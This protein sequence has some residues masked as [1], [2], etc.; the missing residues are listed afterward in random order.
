MKS[1]DVE[2]CAVYTGGVQLYSEASESTW[3]RPK[4]CHVNT[5]NKCVLNFIV[6]TNKINLKPSMQPW[7]VERRTCTQPKAHLSSSVCGLIIYALCVKVFMQAQLWCDLNAEVSFNI[8]EVKPRGNDYLSFAL[9]IHSKTLQ[10]RIINMQEYEK[11]ENFYIVLEEPK[12]L[13][14]GISGLYVCTY[15]C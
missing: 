7:F 5:L 10:V 13:K 8:S 2:I 9:C 12:W 14:R 15:P 3:Q 1:D 11:R 4:S 6:K